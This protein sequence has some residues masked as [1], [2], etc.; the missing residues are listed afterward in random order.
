MGFSCRRLTDYDLKN[1]LIKVVGHARLFLLAP[2]FWWGFFIFVQGPTCGSPGSTGEACF[3]YEATI[4]PGAW[5]GRPV[6]LGRTWTWMYH[7]STSKFSDWNL[8]GPVM[9]VSKTCKHP[10]CMLVQRLL[11]LAQRL[12]S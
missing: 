3:S 5:K 11:G 10:I 7:P 2:P 1:I 8:E 9:E 4:A 12:Q 6:L